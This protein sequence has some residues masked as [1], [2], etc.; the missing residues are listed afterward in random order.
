MGLDPFQAA[1]FGPQLG[2]LLVALSLG[3]FTASTTGDET[4]YWRE[5]EPGEVC[6]VLISED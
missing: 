3:V 5:C 4:S 2:P 6:C 1:V